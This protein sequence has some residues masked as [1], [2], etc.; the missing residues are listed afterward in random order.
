M[1]ERN[2]SLDYSYIL[3]NYAKYVLYNKKILTQ[4][5]E[6][7]KYVEMSRE[8]ILA[9]AKNIFNTNNLYISYANEKNISKEI[10]AILSKQDF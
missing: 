5:Q 3:T 8:D 4:K 2:E 7:K 6:D 10:D 9:T 1:L